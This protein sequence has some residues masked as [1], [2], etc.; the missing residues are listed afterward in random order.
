[1]AL[2]SSLAEVG[3]LER[4]RRLLEEA[5]RI[6]REAYGEDS[7]AGSTPVIYLAELLIRT[8]DFN[9]ARMLLEPALY[10][11]ET[12]L[13]RHPSTANAMKLLAEAWIGLK[14]GERARPLLT[15]A[16][17]IRAEFYGTV[18]PWT[19]MVRELIAAL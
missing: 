4:A 16:L 5:V 13:G 1:M 10:L 14:E 12:R 9:T 15:D 3:D 6:R 8:G 19:D 7:V 18:H 2:G 17:S 11:R